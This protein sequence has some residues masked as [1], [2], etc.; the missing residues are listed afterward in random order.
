MGAR[1]HW[2]VASV[3]ECEQALPVMKL[4]AERTP[5]PVQTLSYSSPSLARAIARHPDPT[6]SRLSAISYAPHETRRDCDEYVDRIDPDQLVLVRYDLWPALLSAARRRGTSIVLICGVIHPDT[7][8]LRWYARPFFR[9]LYGMLDVASMVAER[10]AVGVRAIVTDA[11]DVRVDGDTRYDRVIERARIDHA[12]TEIE[13][14]RE[15][16][17]GRTIL[18]AGSTWREDERVLAD[19]F[20]DPAILTVTVPHE[21]TGDVCRVLKRDAPDAFLISE[22]LAHDPSTIGSLRI[23]SIIVDATGYLAECYAVAAIAYIGGGFGTGVHSV[24]EAAAHG[25]AL[26]SG[27]RIERSPDATE[28]HAMGLLNVVRSRHECTAIVQRFLQQPD[29]RNAVGESGRAFVRE[30]SGATERLAD[31]LRTMA[32]KRA[33]LPQGIGTISDEIDRV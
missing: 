24:L 13:L 14:I 21:P 16:A 22:L 33:R 12:R 19:I 23:G 3:G 32:S 8:R 25:C 15:A 1:I 31:L 30:R 26:L 4:L 11:T 28:M 27:P 10:D 18:V 7:Q 5:E 29:D 9:W 20:A 17:N 6:F 2:H